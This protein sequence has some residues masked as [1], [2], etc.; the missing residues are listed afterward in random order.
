MQH[1][2]KFYSLVPKKYL[3]QP[4]KYYYRKIRSKNKKTRQKYSLAWNEFEDSCMTIQPRKSGKN[5]LNKNWA[6]SFAKIGSYYL[7]KNCFL[8][9]NYILKNCRKIKNIPT[10][11]V[12]GRY[13]MACPPRQAHEL[14]QALPKSKLI[15]TIAGH[16]GSEKQTKKAIIETLD[17][18][19]KKTRA[20]PVETTNK[21]WEETYRKK[22][23]V[24]AEIEPFVKK[25]VPLFRK[26]KVKTILD[27]GC[28]TGK[29]CFFLAKKGFTVYG[30]DSSPTAVRI[31]ARQLKGKQNKKI[32][33]KQSDMT[34]IP[35]KKG[36]FDAVI[37]YRVIYHGTIKQIRKAIREVYRV[38]KP[39][40]L[41]A[42]NLITGNDQDFRKGQEIEKNTFI[43]LNPKEYNVPHHFFTKKEI[44][45]ETKAFKLLKIEPVH[46]PDLKAK[47]P[48]EYHLFLEKAKK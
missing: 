1:S 19:A 17:E 42:L 34:K 45:K 27:L 14:H 9:E 28:G 16:S 6:K 31:A 46:Y 26:K 21:D 20:Q 33:L 39:N 40:G 32:R 3:K 5:R 7:S 38:L 12:Q 37:C 24:H 13:D 23:V 29:N 25:T 30:I 15:Y 2:K 22:G 41:F 8:P 36:S 47:K 48:S 35:F 44:L 43:Y 10:V 4:E 18:M 11:I